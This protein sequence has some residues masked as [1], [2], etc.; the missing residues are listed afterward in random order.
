MPSAIR[1]PLVKPG[2]QAELAPV[3]SD[4]RAERGGEIAVLYQGSVQAG[5]VKKVEYRIPAIH[6][7]AMIYT[8]RI[9]DHVINGKLF[10]NGGIHY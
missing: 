7:V 2:T 8:L 5:V 1:V 9:G 4:I 3:E 10:P 6:R